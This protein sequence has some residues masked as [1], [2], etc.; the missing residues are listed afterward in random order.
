MTSDVRQWPKGFVD[1]QP[2]VCVP[3]VA[4]NWQELM[5]Q[6]NAAAGVPCHLVEW[7]IDGWEEALDRET[8]KATAADLRQRL[9]QPLIG[10][11]RSSREGGF[12][13]LPLAVGIDALI[14]LTE[15][16]LLDYVDIEVEGDPQVVDSLTSA[17]RQAGVWAIGSRHYIDHT[18][19]TTSM[20][21]YLIRVAER[22][23]IPKLSVMAS[24]M[25]DVARLLEATAVAR[26]QG[27]RGPVITM[28]MGPLGA[29]S[30]V[31]GSVFGS[32][33]TFAVAQRASAP[34]QLP[35]GVL[36]ELLAGLREAGFRH[37]NGE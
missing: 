27:V 24:T 7:R 28:A 17:A 18:P 34:G 10:T 16:R 23:Y 11:F 21:A 30:R 31:V 25:S 36:A 32:S 22:G 26:E 2:A 19:P 33:L 13:K 8:V 1:E 29:I 9:H 15:A 20:V 3:L 4:A 35:V 14:G 37:G 5:E 6:A 12:D